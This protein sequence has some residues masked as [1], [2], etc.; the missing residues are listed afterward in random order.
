MWEGT[1]GGHLVQPLWSSQVSWS[2]LPRI[3]SSQLTMAVDSSP[4]LKNTFWN[5]GFIIIFICRYLYISLGAQQLWSL[6]RAGKMID[7]VSAGTSAQRWDM[8]CSS[9]TQASRGDTSGFCQQRAMV[10]LDWLSRTS[11]CALSHLGPGCQKGVAQWPLTLFSTNRK[12]CLETQSPLGPY[13]SATELHTFMSKL[14]LSTPATC[15][16]HPP[17]G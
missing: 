7:G 1:S 5:G 15:H 9:T 3:V 14:N 6:G 12:G 13:C 10:A 4:G 17:A 11:H 16:L 2:R 8:H